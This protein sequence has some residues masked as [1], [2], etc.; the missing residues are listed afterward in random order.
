[1]PR[2]LSWKGRSRAFTL[3]ELLVVIAIIAILIGLLLP[4]VQKVRDAAARMSSTNNLKQMGLCLHNCNDTYGY[5]PPSNGNFPS[6]AT[7]P[8]HGSLHYWLLPFMEQLNLYNSEQP[9]GNVPNVPNGADSW[10]IGANGNGT[11]GG[12]KT[13]VSPGDVDSATLFSQ[14]NNRPGTTYLSNGFVFAQS[15]AGGGLGAVNMGTN[16]LNSPGTLVTAMPDG[17]SNTVIFGEAYVDCGGYGRLWVESNWQ[18]GYQ[19]ACFYSNALPQFQPSAPNCNS[20]L[21]QGHHAGTF[22]VG[23]GDGSVRGVSQGVSQNTWTLALY[24]NDGLPLGPDW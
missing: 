18:P 2:F 24:P 10:W 11:P 19:F 9:N 12:V 21:L 13:F 6:P 23:M 15:G 3:I 1:M 5:L 16:N 7:S 22:L 20:G 8:V 17:T 14:N 4:A